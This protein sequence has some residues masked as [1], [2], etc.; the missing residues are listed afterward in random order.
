M[1]ICTLAAVAL[2]S[3]LT[4]YFMILPLP[5]V[6][7][8]RETGGRLTLTQIRI[9]N[10]AP[11]TKSATGEAVRNP[12]STEPIFE[13][14]AL[15]DHINQAVDLQLPC[16]T[17]GGVFP[18]TVTQLRFIGKACKKNEKNILRS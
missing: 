16:D 5:A 7:N 11:T 13:P 8:A 18:T 14:V 17:K 4:V 10:S 9:E 3:I 6:M 12:A 1:L 15:A 2:L